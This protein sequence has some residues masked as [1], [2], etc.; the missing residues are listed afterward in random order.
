[1]AL[2]RL[3]RL[4][5]LTWLSKK[6]RIGIVER[7]ADVA[8]LLGDEFT[9]GFLG[10]EG[11]GYIKE[12]QLIKIPFAFHIYLFN[13]NVSP[14]L[15]IYLVSVR[16]LNWIWIGNSSLLLILCPAELVS[17]RHRW[18]TTTTSPQSTDLTHTHTVATVSSDC[19]SE[20]IRSHHI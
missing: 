15:F 8:V 7:K 11:G 10:S 20:S 5:L 4:G 14:L 17:C 18:Q 13:S 9:E 12:Q 6:E 2:P 3:N 16:G 19:G 1:M